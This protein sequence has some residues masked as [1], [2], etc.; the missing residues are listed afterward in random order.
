MFFMSFMGYS[1]LEDFEGTSTP[2]TSGN[3]VLNT[4]TWKVFDNGVGVLENWGPVTSP[5]FTYQGTGRSADVAAEGLDVGSRSEEWLVMPRYVMAAGQQ[6]RFFTRQGLSGDNGT[7]Y[8]IRVSTNADPTLMSEYETIK[9]YTE[10]ELNESPIPA[11][12]Y[13]EKVVPL[14]HTGQNLYIAFVKV[15]TQTVTNDGD[16]W[17][18]DNVRIAQDCVKPEIP[19]EATL[20]TA[21][22]AKLNWTHSGANPT[23]RQYEVRYGR[24][25]FSL[26][27]PADYTT[28]TV[29]GLSYQIPTG[30]Q[31]LQPGT[32]Y[33]FAVRAFCSDGVTSDWSIKSLF[34]TLEL[35]ATCQYPIVVT[36]PL[37]YS[38]ISNTLVYGNHVERTSP[39]SNCGGTGN[40]LESLDAV[41]SY[42]AEET[43]LINISMN[44]YGSANTGVFVYASCTTIGSTCLAGVANA[45]ANV[46]LIPS[47]SV[48]ANQTY[49][50]VVS[51]KDVTFNFDYLLLIQK[52]SCT[53]PVTQSVS[54]IT[55]TGATLAWTMPTGSTTT[56][57]QYVVQPAGESVP[58]NTDPRIQ[59][60]NSTTGNPTPLNLTA[61]TNYQFWV[62]ADCGNGTFSAWTGPFLFTTSICAPANQCAFTFTLR[63]TGG[64]GWEGGQMQVR[65]NGVV[66]ATLGTGFTGSGPTN[67]TVNLCPGIPFDLF[68]NASGNTPSEIR[69]AVKNSFNQELYNMSVASAALFNTVLTTN[70][71]DCTNPLCLAPTALTVT[72]IGAR[73]A[74]LGWNVVA[75]NP[76]SYDIFVVPNGQPIPATPTYPGVT[77]NSFQIPP[78]DLT[79][80]TTY[81]YFIRSTCSVNSPSDISTPAKIFTTGPSCVRPTALTVTEITAYTAKLNW[82][83]GA[84]AATSWQVMAIPVGDPNPAPVAGDT[85]WIDAPTNPFVIGT[86]T[87]LL[88]DT[89]YNFYV[90]GNCG[91]V[92][93]YSL[94]AGPRAF[95]TLITCI[96]PTAPTA[97]EIT[98][99]SVKVGWNNGASTATSWQVLAIPAGDPAPTADTPGWVVANTNPFVLTGLTSGTCYDYYVRGN[100]GDADGVSTWSVAK[101][102]CTLI[103]EESQ[104]CNYVFTFGGSNWSGAV[105][106]I[107]QNN[108][109]IGTN[110][111]A[112]GTRT[113]ALCDGIPFDLSW[114]VAGTAPQNVRV[115]SIKNSFGQ[116][117]YSMT[118]ASPT[119]AGTVLYTTSPNCTTVACLPPTNLAAVPDV[120]SAN[121]TWTNL[122][123]P[124]SPNDPTTSW[125]VYNVVNGGPPP[126]AGSG[127]PVS[128]NSYTA[129]PLLPSTTYQFYVSSICSVNS[130]SIWAG[131]FTYTTLPTC[132][133][134]T[135]WTVINGLTGSATISWTEPGTATAW[136]VGYSVAGTGLPPT[137]IVSIP[138]EGNPGPPVTVPPT[139]PSFSTPDSLAPGFYEFYI[140]SVCSPTDSSLWSGPIPFFVADPPP[141][142]AS[143]EVDVVT[144]AEGE[145]DFCPGDNCIDLT[146]EYTDVKD[147]TNYT[148][149]P[150]AFAPPF[151]F[152][153]GI[154]FNI[155]QDDI[156]GPQFTLPFQFC[157]YG[158]TYSKVQVG[159]NGIVSFDMRPAGSGSGYRME[160]LQIP[161]P[162]FAI[163][164]AIY[165]VNQDI[166]PTKPSPLKSINYQVL[167]EAPC[168][169]FVVN[170]YQIA[171]FGSACQGAANYQTSQV[172]MYETSNIIE[173]YVQDRVPCLSWPSDDTGGEGLIGI[174][175]ADGTLAHVP[176][177]RNTGPWEAHNEA[178]RFT[179]NGASNVQ[180]SWLRGTEVVGT[181][182][183]IQVC[184][185]ETT[186]V[187]AKA[188]YTGC[189][190]QVTTKTKDILLKINAVDVQPIPDVNVCATTYQLPALTIGNYFNNPGGVD[191]L[192]STLLTTS[193]R[194]YVYA[195]SNTVPNCTD[196]ESFMVT[197]GSITIPQS[198][199]IVECTKYILPVLPDGFGYYTLP[200]GGGTT[201]AALTE[202][203]ESILPL[204]IYGTVGECTGQSQFNINI[205][206]IVAEEVNDVVAC[207]SYTLLG[208]PPNNTYYTATGGP[209][210]TGS[211]LLPGAV[212]DTNQT[213]YVYAQLGTGVCTDETEFTV[214]ITSEIIPTFEPITVCVGA[215]ATLP[216]ASD[217][218][219]AGT[220][221]QASIDTSVSGTFTYNF[222]PDLTITPCA[223]PGTLTVNVTEPTSPNFSFPVYCLGSAIPAFETTSNGVTGTWTPDTITTTG[224][225]RFTVDAGQCTT[226]PFYDYTITVDGFIA[227]T[228]T[229]VIACGSYILPALPAPFNYYTA[230][231]GTGTMYL[232]TALTQITASQLP[233]YIRAANASCSAEGSYNI[234]I[235]PIAAP[236]FTFTDYC[237]GDA[238][239]TLEA[240]SQN[241]VTG[242]WS[243]AVITTTGVY[244]FTPA[245]TCSTQPFY[246][247]TINVFPVETPV[248]TLPTFLCTGTTAP[249]LPGVSDNS[250]VGTWTPS[251]ISS[252]QS[253]SYTFNPTP[254]AAHCYA[255][256]TLTVTISDNPQFAIEGGCNTSNVYEIT[257]IL[258][259][260]LSTTPV[261][262]SWT[263]PTGA[264]AG[265][266][267]SIFPTMGGNYKLKVTITA[268]GCSAEEF[269]NVDG[270]N[271]QIQRGISPKGVG[272]GDG[273]NDSF[274]LTGMNVTE[275][276]IFN[277]YGTKVYSLNNY[278]NQWY[279][280]SK[281]GDELP[282]GTYYYV[283]KRNTAATVT[284][285]IYI[286]REK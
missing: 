177:G 220:W 72:A 219:I 13:N 111:T 104:K 267:Q 25:G 152:T 263:D 208:L 16:R 188:V 204:Y 192:P 143:I 269:W 217:N 248:F 63:D 155:T 138:S 142:C 215:T 235:Q 224:V 132:P 234:T 112:A 113:V 79:P 173:V 236:N 281:K 92:D 106:R 214:A 175:N 84:S 179:P 45:N 12:T 165:G 75:P 57:W 94:P 247:Y 268:T 123:G 68:W 59:G 238:L 202:I 170:F 212:I 118:T 213:I 86:T 257:G 205:G 171:P 157:F 280:Q 283:I 27:N 282:D 246:D 271:C 121:L 137:T 140:R 169:A 265:N 261:T 151:P 56:A 156:W 34:K 191:P 244:R 99:N 233:I 226:Q 176:P 96:R 26:D 181:N 126:T 1:Q 6:L 66:V 122:A 22:D 216:L 166:D 117:L 163:K 218:G 98:L 162:A 227:P 110:I 114:D 9:T 148:V 200:D 203:T 31:S 81:Q 116:T 197:L 82:N 127:V 85:R 40:Y 60:S 23:T 10:N 21:Y 184:F 107:R 71:V 11:N 39:G 128:T 172:V 17:L 80:D 180:F 2:D 124:G 58:S 260:S 146:A 196:E 55:T 159:S 130:P 276:E 193:Q 43:G 231:N 74:V 154:P 264:P 46:R 53:A 186:T 134:P 33:E 167:G 141:V 198:E 87:P 183:S 100:C 83:N 153:G 64:D 187:T 125:M 243:P 279:G 147:T 241:G 120:F 78:N 189:G 44:P 278:T 182:P 178:W 91:D 70:M 115:T 201:Y 15:F 164:N 194:V 285:W 275:L 135:A 109:V 35:G 284:G 139:N 262:Y 105:L 245:G 168:R 32:I 199:D 266:T 237:A 28:A 62:R 89:A 29:T 255:P 61:G 52:V 251:A 230:A 65:Q 272:P 232:G 185:N 119:L 222:Q 54:D 30:V 48:T 133:Q 77:G 73:S 108:V 42:T 97:S 51:S 250:I 161:D 14:G 254:A 145:I 174:Q 7:L 47:F 101:N 259:T 50:I 103:C 240:T 149:L 256:F 3:W 210:G 221:L 67:V 158:Q 229:D 253:G 207:T 258:D 252:T 270:I 90:R 41:Y 38:D 36:T 277:R 88:R 211:I 37:P 273:K 4:G 206:D 19:N 5:S 95:R 242:S 228:P 223:V 249:A 239:P 93:G 190:G 20:I 274:D 102:F 225:Y 18:I 49:Y 76:L 8:E 160:G 209:N 131:P 129:D 286:N 195:E 150:A 24:L 144:N 69:I 136:E